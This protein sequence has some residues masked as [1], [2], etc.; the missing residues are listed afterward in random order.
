MLRLITLSLAL[1]TAYTTSAQLSFQRISIA[2]GNTS[3]WPGEMKSIND[4]LYFQGF[5]TDNGHEL[6]ISDGTQNG[7]KLVKDI[8]QGSSGSKPHGFTSFGNKVYFLA[9]SVSGLGDDLWQT[10]GTEAGTKPVI[11]SGANGTTI[12]SQLYI[13]N[14]K[15]Y[16]VANTTA[17]GYELWESDGT[18]AGTKILKDIKP[19]IASSMPHNF[20]Y[21][22]NK[23]YFSAETDAEGHELWA[24]DGTAT[25]TVLVSDI[26]AGGYGSYIGK[27]MVLNN[28]LYFTASNSS[29]RWL[30]KSAGTAAGTVPVIQLYT[31]SNPPNYTEN[32]LVTGNK[33]YFTFQTYNDGMELW[34]SDGTD[35]GTSLVKDIV[36]G[37]RD[38][39][40]DNL[41][42]FNN[43]VYF[44][45]GNPYR[46]LY[47]TDGTTAGTKQIT[48]LADTTPAKYMYDLTVY[49][50]YLY[51][52][53][54]SDY[55]FQGNLY[56]ISKND[57]PLLNI[58][59]VGSTTNIPI[60]ASGSLYAHN[61]TLYAAAWYDDDNGDEL[62]LLKGIPS[63]IEKTA[64]GK[65]T[66]TLYPNPA[67]NMLCIT[68]DAAYKQVRVTLTN[69]V[70]QIILTENTSSKNTISLQG[71]APGIYTAIIDADGIRETQQ[72]TIQ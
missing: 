46:E 55:Y 72:L 26:Y 40:P 68:T 9:E 22:N 67:S 10:D 11:L 38:S 12:K 57:G 25:G 17:E 70:G 65:R 1:I 64:N 44:A 19:G 33:M 29:G 7:T 48:R 56:A 58:R 31:D 27:P 37:Y 20:V 23:L 34:V 18:Y 35:T 52:A 53:F 45:A 59:P 28:T 3:G 24:T 51:F 15:I 2:P 50:D 42:A 5:T 47:S 16:F 60:I 14:G 8:N 30:Y 39:Y 69:T 71:V 21:Y 6:W 49:N 43:K 4:T 54:R 62:W 63:G 61:Q 66:F 13:L 32:T 36:P 41:I